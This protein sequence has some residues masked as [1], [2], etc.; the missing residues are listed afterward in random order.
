MTV[1]KIN[2]I[3]LKVKNTFLEKSRNAINRTEKY[4]YE[5]LDYEA[6]A[7]MQYLR[8]KK[9]DEELDNAK[10]SFDIIKIFLKMAK[11]KWQSFVYTTDSYSRFPNRFAEADNQHAY[12]IRNYKIKWDYRDAVKIKYI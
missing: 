11:E 8:Y 4:Y 12:P 1:Q 2:P 9:A 7:R 5:S 6:K 3:T 10:S